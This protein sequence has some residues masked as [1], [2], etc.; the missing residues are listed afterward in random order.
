MSKSPSIPWLEEKV[1]YMVLI[2]SA[3]LLVFVPFLLTFLL[4]LT[5]SFFIAQQTKLAF[6]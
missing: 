3:T 1:F 5:P 6:I 4:T 2:S